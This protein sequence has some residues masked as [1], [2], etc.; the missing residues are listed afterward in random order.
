MHVT[1]LGVEPPD[2]DLVRL[3]ALLRDDLQEGDAV[4][5]VAAVHLAHDGEEVPHALG[6]S[7]AQR[8]QEGAP[9]GGRGRRGGGEV[10]DVAEH[11]GRGHAELDEYLLD[12]L[13]EVLR[14]EAV[15]RLLVGGAAQRRVGRALRRVDV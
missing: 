1:H 8:A 13:L 9:L 10:V 5:V 11:D 6:L 7:A 3:E 12:V 4:A 15:R 14:V 2:H